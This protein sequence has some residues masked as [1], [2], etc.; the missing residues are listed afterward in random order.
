MTIREIRGQKNPPLKI[1]QL[2]HVGLFVADLDR[3][4]AFYGDAL[5]LERKA[6]PDFGDKGAWFAIGAEQELHVIE[7]GDA[8]ALPE[9]P[10]SHF[11]LVVA[12]EADAVA[13]LEKRG[14][15][16]RS[17][18]RR[19]DGAVQILIRDPDGHSIELTCH[20]P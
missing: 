8:G 6:R 19:P 5:G 3:S 4:V 20:L 10:P 13:H 14:I 11:A 15:P 9:D 16:I 12:D 7:R 1:L 18:S 17:R 2:N